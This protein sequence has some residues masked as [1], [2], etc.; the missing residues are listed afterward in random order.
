MSDQQS[1]LDYLGGL[2]NPYNK[3]HHQTSLRFGGV[4]WATDEHVVCVVVDDGRVCDEFRVEHAEA[5]LRQIG[6]RLIKNVVERV[7]IER[8]DG[9]VVD[10]M[11]EAGLEVVVFVSRSVKA[12]RQR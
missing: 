2:H 8:R 7:A 6:C 10:A 5:G 11:M 12:F 9:P 4:D 1:S 3:E